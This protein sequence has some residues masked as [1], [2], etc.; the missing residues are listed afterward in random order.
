MSQRLDKWLVYARF[1]KH[2]AKACTLIEEGHVRLNREKVA[3]PAQVVKPGDV[4]TLVVGGHVTVVRVLGE[5]ERRGA[6]TV[7]AALYERI[8]P[9]ASALSP[10]EK[11]D[12]ST[13]PL[14]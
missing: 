8:S 12:A 7:A 4:L 11:P 6:A 14:C 5:A 1:V 13:P 3:K 10:A 2:R 9:D